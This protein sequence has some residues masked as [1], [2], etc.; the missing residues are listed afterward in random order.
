MIQKTIQSILCHTISLKCFSE[1]TMNIYQYKF[2][3][4]RFII[5]TMT[6]RETKSQMACNSA[7]I[8]DATSGREQ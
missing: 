6:V 3:I 1:F 2:Y 7:I 8:A 5:L 4:I